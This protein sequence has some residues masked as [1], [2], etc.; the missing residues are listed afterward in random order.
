VGASFVPPIASPRSPNSAPPPSAAF[1]SAHLSR[2]RY[3]HPAFPV[4]RYE[5]PRLEGTHG[6]GSVPSHARK[7]TIV[8][9]FVT[10]LALP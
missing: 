3:P 6:G 9:S 4:V 5:H 10:N 1:P 2:W 8:P 7:N